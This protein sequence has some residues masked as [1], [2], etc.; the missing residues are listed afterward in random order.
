[1]E[2]NKCTLIIDGNWLLM[3]RLGTM[4][5]K[6][7]T[8]LPEEMK[9][10]AQT[11]LV[12]FIAQSISIC[13]QRL[14]PAVDN[15][16]I[17]KDGGSWRK[18]LEVPWLNQKDDVLYKG[19][20]KKAEGTDWT[21]IFGALDVLCKKFKENDLTCVCDTDIEGDD[22][23]WFWSRVLNH[24]GINCVIWT[25]DADLQQL[26]Q[27]NEEKHS[28]T[29]W[30]ND[31]AGL[32]LPKNLDDGGNDEEFLERAFSFGVKPSDD[33]ILQKLINICNSYT[34][35]SYIDPNDII[36]SKVVCGD[37]SDNIK[38]IAHIKPEGKSKSVQLSKKEW[39]AL[40]EKYAISN[41]KD[42]NDH[43][44]EIFT[45]ILSMKK[46]VATS[47]ELKRWHVDEMMWYNECLVVLDKPMYP[48]SIVE[49]MKSHA[50][51]YSLCDIDTIINNYKVL[52]EESNES[53]VDSFMEGLV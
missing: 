47:E 4:I 22:W 40:K 1:M 41:V 29:A 38:P 25:S 20:R 10:N 43:K 24:R 5:D 16:L 49:C 2:K 7:Q 18:K 44:E 52:T 23:V 51:E 45:D 32:M 11:S 12:D 28:W 46:F 9:K 26:V 21:Y 33:P 27:L 15:V 13:L 48:D 17:V 19:N 31:K 8:D 53:E 37:T 3:S 50:G 36:L 42:L 35:V 14:R 39:N 6:F 30:L 34:K